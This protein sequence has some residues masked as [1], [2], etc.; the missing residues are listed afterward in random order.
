MLRKVTLPL[1]FLLP[2]CQLYQH[3]GH[4]NL[5]A[6]IDATATISVALWIFPRLV[7]L[8]TSPSS[9]SRMPKKYGILDILQ[10]CGPPWPFTG[11][12]L[13]L[14]QVYKS[15]WI[16]CKACGLQNN[17]MAVRNILYHV[18]SLLNNNCK[19]RPLLCNCRNRFVTR[20]NGR[21][22]LY[23]VRAAA[24]ERC[25][26]CC[27]CRDVIRR[28][29]LGFSQL[30]HSRR[31]VRAWTRKLRDLWRWKPLPGDNGEYTAGWEDVVR[32]VLTCSLC[33]WI[34]DCSIVTYSYVL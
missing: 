18:D 24:R 20:T 11:I 7:R 16:Y 10:H 19:Q 13:L 12:A 25:F 22:V 30:W 34:G 9:V 8:T 28:T 1:Y 5:W 15:H 26:L 29:N 6:G 4:G 23:A 17:L 33:M 21:C 32:T 27:P 2:H 31:A 14:W 3:D